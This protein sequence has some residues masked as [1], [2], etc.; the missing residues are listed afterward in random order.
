[1]IGTKIYLAL[2]KG[3]KTGKNPNALLARLSDWL[4]RK[5]TKG[6]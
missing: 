1:M 5:L 4:T 2:Y 6:W 3:K